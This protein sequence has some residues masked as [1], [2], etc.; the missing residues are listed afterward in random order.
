MILLPWLPSG[1][2]KNL[3]LMASITVGSSSAPVLDLLE[4]IGLEQLDDL[5][6][7][8]AIKKCGL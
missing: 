7:R 3:S 4:G 6:S 1:L 2:V 5:N 8:S